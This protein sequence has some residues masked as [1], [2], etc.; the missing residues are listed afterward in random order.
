MPSPC[1][2]FRWFLLM[3]PVPDLRT[4]HSVVRAVSTLLLA[5][6]A[7][8][9]LLYFT[10]RG[11]LNVVATMAL[12]LSLLLIGLL[13][14]G[15]HTGR[16]ASRVFI[17]AMAAP[18]VAV[19]ASQAWH[20]DWVP[21]ELDAP[22]RFLFAPTVLVA[23]LII[24]QEPRRWLGPAFAAAAIGALI[25]I[26]LKPSIAEGCYWLNRIHFGNAALAA[27]LMSLM[28]I[29]WER[30]DAVWVKTLKLTGFAAGL[31]ASI[32]SLSRGGWLSLLLVASV[33][34]L[35][36][37]GNLARKLIT[38][39]A[40]AAGCLAIYAVSPQVQQ[41]I[42]LV[43]RDLAGYS[44]GNIDTSIGIRL[45]HWNAAL[46]LLAEAPMFG[47][48]PRGQRAELSRLATEGLLTP[49]AA[50]FAELHSQ[51]LA[52]ASAYGGLGLAALLAMHL[53]PV[54][55]LARLVRSTDHQ[56]RQSAWM[57][58]CW[59]LLFLGFGLTQEVFSLKSTAALY[60]FW[61]AALTAIA[62]KDKTRGEGLQSQ[63]P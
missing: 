36:R 8:G 2:L 30:R 15:D 32:L 17:L 38:G 50:S 55:L 12:L 25:V 62:L 58:I 47:A 40:I 59:S 4:F 35:F 19:V 26:L 61:M 43:E 54:A 29:N 14:T 57:A 39:T 41:R 51:P 60:A 23:L 9:P 5:L 42:E 7:L 18:L 24:P 21:S 10:V 33:F 46:H 53:V 11:A 3:A 37:Q 56:C 45:Q 27:G 48:G 16:G 52:Y 28:S 49:A 31:A 34:L 22:L 6:L 20:H 63:C 1:V 13:R 44:Q